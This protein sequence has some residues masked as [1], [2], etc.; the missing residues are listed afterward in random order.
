MFCPAV[1]LAFS[2]ALLALCSPA[3]AADWPRWRGPA[4]T[5]HVPADWPMPAK[6]H[7]DL[8][9]LWKVKVGEGVASPVVAGGKVFLMEKLNEQ[10]TATAYDAATGKQLWAVPVDASFEDTQGIG[11]RCT[12]MVDDGRAYFQSRKGI[13]QVLNAADGRPLWRKDFVKDFGAQFIGETSSKEAVGAIRHGYNGQPVVDGDSLIVIAGGRSG[14]SVVALD[15]KTGVLIWKSQSDAPGYAPATI[16]TIHGTKQVVVFTADGC[17]G[18]A[19]D[20]GALLWRM[21]IKTTWAR[22]VTTS[23]VVDDMVLVSSHEHG[24]FGLKVSKEGAGFKAEQAWLNKEAAIHFSSPV[25]VGR[26]L[27]GLGPKK[28]LICLEIATGRIAWSQTGYMNTAG[29]Q[30]HVGLIVMGKNILC[31]TDSGELVLF[32]ANPV[33]FKPVSRVQVSG[34]T[35]SNPAYADGKLY[36]REG[37]GRKTAIAHLISVN[38]LAK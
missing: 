12:P 22:H 9:P 35:W 7:S 28:D 18:L 33:A 6:L 13:L 11:A 4:G 32:E 17:I 10:E 14:A 25:A 23:V 24:V 3:H 38:L 27:Y 15:K 19:F 2:V 5:G 1:R 16:A 21:P 37:T 29:G 20:D 26:H 8:P 36:L 30:A 31:L 34:I